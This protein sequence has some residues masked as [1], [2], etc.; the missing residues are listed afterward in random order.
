[1]QITDVRSKKGLLVDSA[2]EFRPT[3]YFLQLAQGRFIRER[4]DLNDNSCCMCS[5]HGTLGMAMKHA[6]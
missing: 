2:Y 5:A 4:Q 6:L 1:M 3:N